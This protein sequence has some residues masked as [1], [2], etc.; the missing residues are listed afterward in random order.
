MKY[1][2]RSWQDGDVNVQKVITLTTDTT[3]TAYYEAVPTVTATIIGYVRDA[4]TKNPIVG[5][6]VTCDGRIDTTE[7]N[8]YYEFKDIPAGKYTIT[9]TKDGYATQT[10]TVDA[11][12]GGTF[13]VDFDLTP[14]VAPPIL[15]P[16]GLWTFPLLTF[17]RQWIAKLRE[18]LRGG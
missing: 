13:Q 17:I 16:L 5:A 14:V 9:V 8:G 1:V 11:S 2:F 7:A 4:T 6:T 3:L 12:A 10:S 15:G 18:R